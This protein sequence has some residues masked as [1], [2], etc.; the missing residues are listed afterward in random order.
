MRWTYF[1]K[2]FFE[3]RFEYE[4]F[5]NFTTAKLQTLGN[6]LS[7][8]PS[9]MS[10]DLESLDRGPAQQMFVDVPSVDGGL[11]NLSAF[12][13]PGL[14]QKYVAHEVSRQVLHRRVRFPCNVHS[15][16]FRNCWCVRNECFAQDI[17]LRYRRTLCSAGAIVA[18]ASFSF[19]KRAS[20]PGHN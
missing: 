4:S 13:S 3:Y 8:M 18:L 5:S 15:R 12:F 9:I 17:Y 6:M 14:T 7:I 19:V 20:L 16:R 1:R 10:Y 11:V 2:P